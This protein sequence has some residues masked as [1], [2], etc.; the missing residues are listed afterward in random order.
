MPM[1]S[2][3]IT[4]VGEGVRDAYDN[5]QLV[6]ADVAKPSRREYDGRRGA[7]GVGVGAVYV[8]EYFVFLYQTAEGAPD[9]ESFC[10]WSA[11]R[12]AMCNMCN[13][14]RLSA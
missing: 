3:R 14:C 7:V 8:V 12:Q 2:P 6:P 13:T 1:P 9:A 11:A 5:F 10:R 4:T